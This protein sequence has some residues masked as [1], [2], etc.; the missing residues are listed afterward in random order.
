MA[1]PYWVGPAR[2]KCEKRGTCW[3]KE[4]VLGK[5]KAE[6]SCGLTIGEGREQAEKAGGSRG[7]NAVRP[8]S[9]RCMGH[10]NRGAGGGE[11]EARKRKEEENT[12]PK[13]CVSKGHAHNRRNLE[14]GRKQDWGGT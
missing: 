9:R 2:N 1:C 14:G 5:Q 3:K 11:R 4:D 7:E 8:G 13:T 12:W 10:Q 6:N